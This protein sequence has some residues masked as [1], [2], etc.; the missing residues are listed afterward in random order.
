MKKALLI[1]INNYPSGNELYGCLEDINCVEDVIAR[2][3]DGTPNFSVRKLEDV[4]N[5]HEAKEAIK[6]LFHGDGEC[7]LLYF[8][9]HGYLNELGG[10][11]VF[12]DDIS[13]RS[14]YTGIKMNDI[15]QLASDS[16]IRNK[17]IILDCCHS[18]CTGKYNI[19]NDSC[20]IGSGVSILTA[21]REDESAMECGGHGLFTEQLCNALRGGAADFC[22]NITIGGIYAYIDRT[23]GPWQQRPTF[24]TNVTEFSPIKKVIPKV[25]L[26][27]IRQLINL[28]P[29]MTSV[30]P[31]DPSYEC[32]NTPVVDHKVVEPY[33]TAENVKT[34]KMLQ[35][36]QSIG[37]VEPIATDHMYFAAMESLGCRLTNLG[38]HYWKL[39]KDNQI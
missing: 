29:M 36:L 37:F 3:G 38:Q 13:N 23:F 33:A 11:I 4:Q 27:I 24:K 16:K 39:V 10:E 25:P 20:H 32:T 15:L 26:D 8:S 1:G 34:F 28:F 7:A 12:P 19:N 5:S 31:L 18:G 22:G 30:H 21:C 6:Q 35:K 14:C 9:G 2:N 17:V